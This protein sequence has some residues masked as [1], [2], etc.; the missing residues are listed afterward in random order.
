MSGKSRAQTV[1]LIGTL[2]TKGP[3]DRVRARPLQAL[4]LATIVADSASSPG[5]STSCPT[6]RAPKWRGSAAR[7]SRRLRQAGS[8]G[9]A[10]HGMLLGLRRLALDLFRDGRLDGVLLLGGAEGAVLGA[11]RELSLPIGIPKIIVTPIASGQRRFGPLVGTRDVMVVHSVIDILG[12]QPDQ[13]DDLRQR[14][15]RRWPACSAARPSPAEPT[16]GE[17]RVSPSRCSATPPRP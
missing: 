1:L 12:P 8:R 5:R 7:P 16:T 11:R 14:R 2:D 17:P 3:R 13:H 15:R 6:C 10:V 4:G 9:E